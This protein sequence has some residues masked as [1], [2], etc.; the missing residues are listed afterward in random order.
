MR[1]NQWLWVVWCL[2]AGGVSAAYLDIPSF[3]GR[4]PYCPTNADANY[5]VHSLT[6]QSLPGPY[7]IG[8]T[9]KEPD[10]ITSATYK[11]NPVTPREALGQNVSQYRWALSA[12]GDR[13][14]YAL[15]GSHDSPTPLTDVMSSVERTSLMIGTDASLEKR[16]VLY[17]SALPGQWVPPGVYQDIITVEVLSGFFED[18]VMATRVFERPWAVVIPVG[19]TTYARPVTPTELAFNP[20]KDTVFAGRVHYKIGANVPIQITV[21]SQKG[22]RVVDD[23]SEVSVTYQ[24]TQ[25]VTSQ[26]VILFFKLGMNPSKYD[27]QGQATDTVV[28]TMTE[29]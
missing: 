16:H 6:V 27:I 17:V 29:M 9:S 20:I 26:D 28:V 14:R 5:W 15:Y 18:R 1:I 13:L 4:Q 8:F 11:G 24:M 22:Y 25:K 23:Q 21:H 3:V 2:I 19:A 7:M 10:R 12:K